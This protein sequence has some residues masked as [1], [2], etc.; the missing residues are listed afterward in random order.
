MH[1]FQDGD[2][3]IATED[4]W[5]PR[6]KVGD[7]PWML[8]MKGE[9]LVV[10]GIQPLEVSPVRNPLM[11]FEVTPNQIER[12]GGY[13]PQKELVDIKAYIAAVGPHFARL[14]G[15]D[16]NI[17][18]F[19]TQRL[20]NPSIA[21]DTSRGV[22]AWGAPGC[23]NRQGWLLYVCSQIGFWNTHQHAYLWVGDNYSKYA[24]IIQQAERLA[25]L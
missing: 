19:I 9:A 8:A 15:V 22:I 6:D 1:Q 10:R 17:M 4:I 25:G 11:S 20:N 12:S 3:V 5:L 7:P 13:D 23:S 24:P 2:S 18:Q 14:C 21:I 16:P